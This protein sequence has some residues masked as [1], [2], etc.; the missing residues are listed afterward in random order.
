MF[1]RCQRVGNLPKSSAIVE[2]EIFDVRGIDFQ[3]PFPSS[4]GIRYIRVVV[5]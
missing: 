5:D 2:V 3:G 4:F 1:D